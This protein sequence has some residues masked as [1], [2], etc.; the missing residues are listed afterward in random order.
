MSFLENHDTPTVIRAC[1]IKL[2]KQ[3]R[4]LIQGGFREEEWADIDAAFYQLIHAGLEEFHAGSWKKVL[5]PH[6][7]LN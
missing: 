1:S 2:A 3:C 4:N 7:H 6:P 5:E